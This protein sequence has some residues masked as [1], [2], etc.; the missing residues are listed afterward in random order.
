MAFESWNFE[1]KRNASHMEW[2]TCTAV[3][4]YF[5]TFHKFSFYDYAQQSVEVARQRLKIYHIDGKF[6]KS[7]KITHSTLLKQ[8]QSPLNGF[9][10]SDWNITLLNIS[11]DHWRIIQTLNFRRETKGAITYKGILLL[12]TQT[13]NFTIHAICHSF[14]NY[15]LVK[16]NYYK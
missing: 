16:T 7:W 4:V 6:I 9:N 5:T 12:F 2:L 11:L 13:S 14:S 3:Y 10:W 15:N 8:R 1:K